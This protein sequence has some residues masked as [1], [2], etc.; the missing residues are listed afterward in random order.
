MLKSKNNIKAF[1]SQP[2]NIILTFFAFILIALTLY[3][4]IELVHHTFI[5]HA[6]D[7]AISPGM[8]KGDISIAS[9]KKLLF[10]KANLYSLVNFYKPMLNSILLATLSAIFALIFGGSVAWLITRSNIKGKKFKILHKLIMNFFQHGIQI[11][12][13]IKYN[14]QFYLVV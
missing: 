11:K 6:T 3:P 9:W 7:I 2:A 10:T 4:L 13:N 5:M 8:K 12:F 1:F 14:K